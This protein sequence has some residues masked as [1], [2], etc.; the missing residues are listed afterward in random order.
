MISSTGAW[1]ERILALGFPA[2]AIPTRAELGTEYPWQ[3]VAARSRTVAH[4]RAVEAALEAVA[5]TQAAMCAGG[6]RF[7]FS[8]GKDSTAL[9][10]LLHRAGWTLP[11][12][13]V[14]DDLDYPGERP[15]VEALCRRWRVPLDVLTPAGS[16]FE[17]LRGTSL[18]EGDLHSRSA[19][20]SRTW[21]YEPLDAYH[22]REG[23]GGVV[24]GL[25]QE[26][27]AGRRMNVA[28]RGLLY[29]RASGLWVSQPI[30]RW[31][32]LDVHAFCAAA[33]V[34]LLPVYLC[35]DPGADWRRLRKSWWVC[36]GGPARHGHYG[37]LRR[38]W[39]EQW[40]RAVEIDA[41]VTRVS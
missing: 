9:G 24:L 8:G 34:P 19:A 25:R 5:T 26:E 14:K 11:A 21:F 22:E 37:W 10:G 29:M 32:T 20:L 40:R 35:V 38:W 27:S 39:P 7:G 30:A 41:Q 23:Y 4:G 36:G 3:A 16:L 33:D 6:W 18:V 2:A 15:F 13:S 17:S 12:M 28:T 31:S 1:R